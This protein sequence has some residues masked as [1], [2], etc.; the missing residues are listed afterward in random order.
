MSI[1]AKGFNGGKPVKTADP[2]NAQVK[3]WWKAKAK[4]IYALIPDFGGFLVKA[5]SEG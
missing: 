3:A 1:P 5:N 4:E 2:L